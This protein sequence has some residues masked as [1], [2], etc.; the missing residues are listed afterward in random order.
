MTRVRPAFSAISIALHW[1][2]AAGIVGMLVFG[3]VIGAMESGPGKTATIQ[4][5]KSFGILVGALALVRLLW[6]VHEGFPAAIPMARWETVAARGMHQALLIM[7]V[8]M[9]V[10]GILK[11]V[12]YARPVNVFGLPV[13]PQL[14]AEKN[15]LFN[16]VVS[17]MHAVSG[18][19]LAAMVLVHAA[20]AIKHHVFD[21]DRTLVRMLGPSRG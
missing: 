10:T 14:L 6:R 17:A 3:M 21:R 2:V 19:L 12:S 11:S 13:L 7:T 1:L 5:H 20:A 18:Y 8:L 9:P 4:I 15:E 16:E